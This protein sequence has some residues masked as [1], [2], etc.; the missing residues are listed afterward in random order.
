MNRLIAFG[1]SHTWGHGLSYEY[2]VQGCNSLPPH[3]DSWPFKLGVK[4][5]KEVINAATTGDSTKGITH[6]IFNFKFQPDDIVVILWTH[7]GRHSIIKNIGSTTRDN[8]ER[9]N[10][11][12]VDRFENCKLYYKHFYNEDDDNFNT[13]S[14]IQSANYTLSRKKIKVLNC[15]SEESSLKL[16][17]EYTDIP[18]IYDKPFLKEYSRYGYG[19]ENVHL[20]KTSHV[21]FA[22]DIYNYLEAN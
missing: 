18:L 22:E 8:Y 4:L 19:I 13:L 7:P 14:Y 16:I 2:N 10:Y 17:R 12:N 20:G 1:C 11:Y 9:I 5:D 3:K 21:K 15:F 6:K